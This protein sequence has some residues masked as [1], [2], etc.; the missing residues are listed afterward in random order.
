MDV[1]SGAS[2]SEA[3]A[4]YSKAFDHLYVNMVRAGEAGGMLDIVLQ[5]LAEFREKAQRL[6]RRVIGAMIYPACVITF[7]FGILIVI[8][9]KV[10]PS[11]MDMFNDLGVEL[12]TPTKIL[13]RSSELLQEYWYVLL[14]SPIGLFLLYK[15]IRSTTF[16]GRLVDWL[17]FHV[18][19]FGNVLH[20]SAIARFTRTFGT[21]IGSGVPILEALDI[22]RATAGN[23]ILADAISSVHDSIREGD[24]IAQPLSESGVC[25]QIVV[26][27]IDV[28]EETGNLDTMLIRIADDYDEQVDVAVETLTSAMEPIMVVTLG[29]IIGFIVISLFLP[30]VKLMGSIG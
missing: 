12:P 1:E 2:L 27:M 11:F 4:N 16:G 21:L 9:I 14:F 15:I 20:K 5:R 17:K 19:V 3:M 30:L 29:L 6:K 28:G 24:P 26:N 10:I 23:K 22:S 18:P 25:D 7:A 13:L 8:M